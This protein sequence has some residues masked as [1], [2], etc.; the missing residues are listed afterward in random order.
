MRLDA[1]LMIFEFAKFCVLS[2]RDSTGF[3]VFWRQRSLVD[4]P[5]FLEMCAESDPPPFKNHNF[6]QYL[7]I[8]PQPWELAKKLN[9]H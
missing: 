5:L 3:L 6:D 2:P 1:Q 8:A 9:K 7:L 4:K